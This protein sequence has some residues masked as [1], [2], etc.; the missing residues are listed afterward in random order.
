MIVAMRQTTPLCVLELV[1]RT[2]GSGSQH[3]LALDDISLTIGLGEFVSIT[4]PSGSGK[5]TLLSVI[6]LLEKF[7]SGVYILAGQDVS[8][9]GFDQRASIRNQNI[10]LIFQAFNLLADLTVIQNVSLPLH[11]S[12]VGRRDHQQLAAYALERVGMADRQNDF[13]YQ[14]SGGQQQRVAIARAIVARPPLLLADE[15]TG[16]LDSASSANVIRILKDLNED[17]STVILVTHDDEQANAANRRII[18]KDGRIIGD[19]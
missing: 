13:P 1:S 9:F 12:R 3:I 18:M 19:R 2:Y 16:N 4:G 5:S 14:L 17:G 10:G 8:R 11:Y 6:G 7:D 15:P